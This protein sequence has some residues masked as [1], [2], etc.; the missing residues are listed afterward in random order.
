MGFVIADSFPVGQG[1]AYVK[2]MCIMPNFILYPN[3]LLQSYLTYG[4]GLK[5]ILC[6]QL[7]TVGHLISILLSIFENNPCNRP[8]T[9]AELIVFVFIF[10]K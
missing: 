10:S 2:T 1:T 6:P 9:C 3:R 7:R 4:Q 8:L 5:K